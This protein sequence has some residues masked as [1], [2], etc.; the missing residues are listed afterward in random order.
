MIRN[1]RTVKMAIVLGAALSCIPA[2][3]QNSQAAILTIDIENVVQY[4]QDTSDLTKLATIPNV[5][6][7]SPPK[8]F[9]QQVG[10][11][12]I[13]AINGLP[14]KGTLT[15][16]VRNVALVPNANPG[17][18]V[19]D[20]ARGAVVMDS[21]EILSSDGSAVGTIVTSGF[22]PGTPAPGTP[23][24]VTQGNYAI[25]GGTGAFLGIR[26]QS[27]QVSQTIP[28]RLASMTEDPAN[29]RVNGGGK[30]RWALQLIPM[31]RPEIIVTSSGP[32]VAH[33]SDFS[34]V[35]AAKPAAAGEILSLFMTGLGPT[36]PG[37][38][39]GAPFPSSPA[40][41]VNSPVS[42]TVNGKSAE[43]IGAVGYP[44]T[45]GGYQLNFRVPSDVAKGTATIQVAAAWIAGTPV[46]IAVQ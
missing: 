27:G 9:A 7:P 1:T 45:V 31:D 18:A 38:D 8:N 29:R 24:S 2:K 41:V 35:T 12:D 44:N 30:A 16:S 43:V 13:V 14:A 11:G 34:V 17:Q 21:F 39:P 4:L 33:S 10:F 20:T 40:A 6:P 32:A 42:V 28:I 15:R 23:Q 19:A 37:V 26:G 3:A 46:T 5:T 25:I 22:A 36:R